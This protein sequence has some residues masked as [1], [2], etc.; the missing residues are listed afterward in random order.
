[1]L[2]VCSGRYPTVSHGL[3]IQK[4]KKKG[5]NEDTDTN[6]NKPE[7]IK[8][9]ST[10]TVSDVISMSIVLVQIT[11]TN[12]SKKFTLMVSWIAAARV[13]SYWTNWQM[14]L[15]YLEE[16]PHLQSKD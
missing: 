11:S 7:E 15:Q 16:R 6:E 14:T 12:T 13:H 10:N 9:A 8:F 4:H 1:M 2:K 3:K 5:N